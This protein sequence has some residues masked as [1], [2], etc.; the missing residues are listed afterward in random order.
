MS[1]FKAT[2]SFSIFRAMASRDDD[3][4]LTESQKVEE[5]IP[6]ASKDDKKEEVDAELDALLDSM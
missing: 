2:A 1:K 3:Q 5:K 6:E 4:G